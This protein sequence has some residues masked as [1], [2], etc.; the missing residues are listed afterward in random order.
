M[1]QF[2]RRVRPNGRAFFYSEIFVAFT[3][4]VLSIALHELFHIIVHWGHITKIEL[5]PDHSA[6]VAVTSVTAANYNVAAEEA[7]AYG[8]TLLTMVTT[9]AILYRMHD[10]KDKK[11]FVHTV[12]PRDKTM[13]QLSHHELYE[14]AV[15]IKLV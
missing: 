4:S 15:R 6:I 2:A 9:V 13:Q 11:S 10:K 12:F 7:I 3:G 14:L 5:F 8:I 1:K